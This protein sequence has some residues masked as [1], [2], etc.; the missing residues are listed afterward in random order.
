VD[1]FSQ[2]PYSRVSTQWSTDHQG[3]LT[4]Y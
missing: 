2:Q 3:S 4:W 1:I